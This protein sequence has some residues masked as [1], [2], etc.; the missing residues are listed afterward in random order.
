MRF[1]RLP[2]AAALALALG[3]TAAAFATTPALASSPT[4]T[5]TEIIDFM[6]S[7]AQISVG[8]TQIT[9]SGRVVE[10]DHTSVG[11]AGAKVAPSEVMGGNGGLEILPTVTTGA[12]GTFTYQ[13]SATVGGYFGA[14]SE[15]GPGYAASSNVAGVK[16][17]SAGEPT[18][19]TLNP[20]PKS[21]VWAGTDLTFTGKAE[22]EASDG[23]W[24][25]L[26]TARAT[27]T[28]LISWSTASPGPPP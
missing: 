26:V 24:H 11:V 15:P 18:R 6:S 27:R 3:G 25:P 13:V 23:Q 10:T 22:A 21:L 16:V 9:L 8:H 2:A 7:P 19:I 12:D 1:F 17:T 20:Q 28:R 4:P 14:S 5:P